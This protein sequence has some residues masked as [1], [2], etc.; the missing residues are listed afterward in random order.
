MRGTPAPDIVTARC[1]DS[2]GNKSEH[3]VSVNVTLAP[4]VV[5]RLNRLILVE[6]YRLSSY[7]GNYGAGR[8]LKTF[9]L[10]PG[11]KTKLSIKN[12]T[13]TETDARSFQHPRFVQRESPKEIEKS[14]ADEQSNKKNYEEALTTKWAWKQRRAGDG[15]APTPAAK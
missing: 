3:S 10:L 5:N 7:L 2:A 12:Y 14:I 15:E 11:E 4:E 8:T 1:T 13:K 9:S 6:S